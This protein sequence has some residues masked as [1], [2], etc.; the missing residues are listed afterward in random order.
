M[1]F[2]KRERNCTL[3]IPLLGLAITLL[4]KFSAA[5][6]CFSSRS[7]RTLRPVAASLC[8]IL[9]ARVLPPLVFSNL[10]IISKSVLFNFYTAKIQKIFQSAMIKSNLF[11]SS[12]LNS[13]LLT[14]VCVSVIGLL[15]NL[16]CSIVFL[17][18]IENNFILP[19]RI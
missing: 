9:N 5:T 8:S 4:I 2:I 3:L 16:C 15:N 14:I 13:L 17:Q 1:C 7:C 11:P 12:A 19:L 18:K 6:S 10:S